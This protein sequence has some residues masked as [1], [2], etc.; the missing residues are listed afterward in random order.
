MSQPAFTHFVK[1][2]FQA[3]TSLS[4]FI[5]FQLSRSQAT[6]TTDGG[7]FTI[8]EI[9][10]NFTAVTQASKLPVISTDR[11]VVLMDGMFV[12]GQPVSGGSALYVFPNIIILLV[13]IFIDAFVQRGSRPGHR[14]DACQPRY[15]HQLGANPPDICAGDLRLD[16][17]CTI[18]VLAGNLHRPLQHQTQHQLRFWVSRSRHSR[19]AEF[20]FI[21]MCFVCSI[22][23]SGVSYPVHPI[24][25]ISA[26]TDDNGEVVCFSGFPMS[27]G[28]SDS[29]DFLLGDSFLRN[30]YSLFAFG[31]ETST[32]N[33]APPS[34]IQLQSVSPRYLS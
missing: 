5:T 34:Y 32:A 12:N 7:I 14:P 21:L 18:A 15:R 24:D 4:T 13:V 23:H 30:V 28:A 31:K 27:D 8:G 25:A 9:D 1:Q 10:S 3:N 29:E 11:W 20:V 26:T 6:G 17:W 16:P 2:V 19:N 22:E 33:G